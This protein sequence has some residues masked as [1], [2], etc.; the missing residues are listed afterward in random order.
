LRCSN[1]KPLGYL[2]QIRGTS[3]DS[4]ML[5]NSQVLAIRSRFPVFTSKIY[6]NS[7]SQGA[8][9]NA[10]EGGLREYVASWREHGSPWDLRVEQREAAR[11]SFVSSALEAEMVRKDGDG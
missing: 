9:S 3:S 7:C 4:I 5:T 10:A 1:S 6:L 11:Q 2:A 8:L